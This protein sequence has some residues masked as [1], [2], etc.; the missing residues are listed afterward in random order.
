ME[1]SGTLIHSLIFYR[2]VPEHGQVGGGVGLSVGL[3]ILEYCGTLCGNNRT[4]PGSVQSANIALGAA[5]EGLITRDRAVRHV[6]RV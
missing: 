4:F 5:P 1:D 6:S 3:T 2:L